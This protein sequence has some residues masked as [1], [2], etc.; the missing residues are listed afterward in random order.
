MM[1]TVRQLADSMDRCLEIFFLQ[2]TFHRRHLFPDS[3]LPH[4]VNKILNPL[5]RLR[6]IGFPLFEAETS[7]YQ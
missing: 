5:V 7:R 1:T 6:T 2:P 4:I 3:H